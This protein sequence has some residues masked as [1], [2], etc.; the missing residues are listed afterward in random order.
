MGIIDILTPYDEMKKL[1]HRFKAL[2]SMVVQN[3][4]SMAHHGT[5]GSRRYATIGVGSRVALLRSTQVASAV[6]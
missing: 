1:E 3:H 4:W 2:L 5:T 6:S